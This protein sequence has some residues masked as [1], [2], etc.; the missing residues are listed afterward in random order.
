MNEIEQKEK[1]LL[2]ALKWY[3][4]WE[5][6]RE[7]YIKNKR[8]KESEVYYLDAT[9]GFGSLEEGFKFFE[10]LQSE[11]DC[12]EGFKFLIQNCD[13]QLNLFR[14]LIVHICRPIRQKKIRV[15]EFCIYP[16]G[17]IFTYHILSEED[18]TWLKT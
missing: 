9:K 8:R 14:E 6:T 7:T 13:R 15:G 18:R 12:V 2:N 3:R 11:K 17:N 16:Y 5:D 4:E 10:E 1:D